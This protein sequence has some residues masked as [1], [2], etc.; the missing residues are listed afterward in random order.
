MIMRI[1]TIFRKPFQ[2]QKVQVGLSKREWVLCSYYGG[3][4]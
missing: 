4:W 1:K 2:V 3:F